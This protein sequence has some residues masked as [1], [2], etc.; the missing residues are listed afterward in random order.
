MKIMNETV[1]SKLSILSDDE[2]LPNSVDETLT[3]MG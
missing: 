3:Q 2:E 1:V